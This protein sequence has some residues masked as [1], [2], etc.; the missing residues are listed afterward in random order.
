VSERDPHE[1]MNPWPRF[2]YTADP[3]YC[4]AQTTVDDLTVTCWRPAGHAGFHQGEI[5]ERDVTYGW[6]E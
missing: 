3:R 1:P 2:D 4:G 5:V 6:N